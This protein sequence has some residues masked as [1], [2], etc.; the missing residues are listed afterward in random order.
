DI[1][2]QSVI[3]HSVS[4]LVLSED[5]FHE[6]PSCKSRQKTY[7]FSDYNHS[8]HRIES[9]PEE[10]CLREILGQ[11]KYNARSSRSC[12]INSFVVKPD[13]AKPWL[14]KPLVQ[15][16]VILV[17]PSGCS[18]HQ[19]FRSSPCSVQY[20]ECNHFYKKES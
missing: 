4:V 12:N 13:L 11:H 18:L 16:P 6:F 19:I 15:F 7:H 3:R 9:C 8:E 10:H 5:I 14:H 20:R 2:E 1:S 17:K